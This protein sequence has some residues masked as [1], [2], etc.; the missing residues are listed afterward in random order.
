MIIQEMP[1]TVL[2]GQ[3]VDERV[4]GRTNKHGLISTCRQIVG[5]GPQAIGTST[6]N[7][8]SPISDRSH[9]LLGRIRVH[10]TQNLA[11]KDCCNATFRYFREADGRPTA[12]HPGKCGTVPL[13]SQSASLL[14]HQTSDKGC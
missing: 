12:L 2:P 11:A 14:I 7:L 5:E 13:T 6:L 4:P 8:T 10:W 9:S 1:Y 3:I